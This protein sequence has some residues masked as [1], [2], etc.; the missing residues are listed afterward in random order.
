V[1]LEPAADVAFSVTFVPATKACE[2]VRPHLMPEIVETTVPDPVPLFVT[3]N[4]LVRAK[5]AVTDLAA[6]IVMLQA[7]VPEHAPDQPTNFEPSDAVAVN[8]TLAL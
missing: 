4:V 7:P 1:N 5:L 3:F 8:V 6:L 2:H